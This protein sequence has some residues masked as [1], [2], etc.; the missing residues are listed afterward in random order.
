MDKL[1]AELLILI[2]DHLD[3][4]SLRSWVLTAKRYNAA[5]TDELY[6]SA[7]RR[8]EETYGHPIYLVLAAFYNQV[9]AFT[10]LLTQ[11]KDISS[12]DIDFSNIP[13]LIREM[14]EERAGPMS[15][16]DQ[17]HAFYEAGLE[18][19]RGPAKTSLLQILCFFG[20][21]E[22]VRIALAHGASVT[23]FDRW[24]RTALHAAIGPRE[25]DLELVNL[26]IAAG[27]DVNATC[28]RS[29]VY[30]D[31]L[32]ELSATPME[33]AIHGHCSAI[34]E[35]LVR[36]GAGVRVFP[37]LPI[38][39]RFAVLALAAMCGDARSVRFILNA[40]DFDIPDLTKALSSAARNTHLAVARML[41][42]AGA[43]LSYDALRSAASADNLAVLRL[44]IDVGAD[45]TQVNERGETVLWAVSS[46][47]AALILLE[48][49]PSL[50]TVEDRDGNTCLHSSLHRP[51]WNLF[52]SDKSKA[53]VFTLIE[54]GARFHGGWDDV[55]EVLLLFAT[56]NR[57]GDSP[58]H[59]PN[60]TKL[61]VG[62]NFNVKSVMDQGLS[63]LQRLFRDD[64]K[65]E[66]FKGPDR[67]HAS[68]V[69][70]LL[71]A[72]ADVSIRSPDCDTTALLDALKAGYWEA[73]LVLMDAG[74]LRF[75]SPSEI[76]KAFHIA[77]SY[78]LPE[79]FSRIHAFRPGFNVSCACLKCNLSHDETLLHVSVSRAL[80][81]HKHI[82]GFVRMLGCI[83]LG[84]YDVTVGEVGGDPRPLEELRTDRRG[85][86]EFVRAL[87]RTG[88]YSLSARNKRGLTAFDLVR[89]TGPELPWDEIAS[90]LSQLKDGER[91]S[92]LSWAAGDDHLD[93]SGLADM[94]GGGDWQI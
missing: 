89:A 15:H 14:N 66:D 62:M 80:S 83:M 76:H 85:E 43:S 36:E 30:G 50:A 32:D 61:L 25:C 87:C 77:V 60:F 71:H 55:R 79:V 92:I 35:V 1:P 57:L 26:L 34:V 31:E 27:A 39:D 93:V 72:G 10:K 86:L 58:T 13:I 88:A 81:R 19:R 75:A 2:S 8:D 63:V 33:L 51:S 11:T 84:Y 70:Y 94:F 7:V 21:E 74:I 16:R 44:L 68:L 69:E 65:D 6:P 42:D 53:L 54:Y 24:G 29:D 3:F 41:L 9:N 48:R 46:L 90:Q 20:H 23:V 52:T 22:L 5:L 67:G 78:R 37:L 12:P 47:E 18:W 59:K 28:N 45:P 91:P 56:S 38:P 73:V 40:G 64:H 49:A 4:E 17:L 82:E